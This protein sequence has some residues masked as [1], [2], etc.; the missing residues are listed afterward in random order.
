[1]GGSSFQAANGCGTIDIK[2]NSQ[3]DKDV[4]ITVCLENLQR[5][6]SQRRDAMWKRF[7][8]NFGVAAIC[9]VPGLWNF[10]SAVSE[11]TGNFKLVFEF[12]ESDGST[13][14]RRG[15]YRR[16]RWRSSL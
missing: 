3:L 14:R 15:R 10:T 8:H 12:A 11:D 2:C 7:V 1:M 4:G 13:G 5:A 16:D 9:R 6:P